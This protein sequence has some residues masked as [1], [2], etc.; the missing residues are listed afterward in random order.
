MRLLIYYCLDEQMRRP[1]LK[2]FLIKIIKNT[3]KILLI[4]IMIIFI[5]KVKKSCQNTDTRLK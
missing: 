4:L 3:G 1:F 5:I 2:F